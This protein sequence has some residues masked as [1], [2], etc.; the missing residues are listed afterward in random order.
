MDAGVLAGLILVAG[1]ALLLLIGAPISI[2]VGLA[3]TLAMF[4][5][6]GAENGALTSAQQMFRGINSFALL[7]IPFF[8]LAGVIMS[9]GGIAMQL[10]NAGKVLVGRVPGSSA[11]T[12]V[13]AN[14]LFGAVSGSSIAA[15][16][17]IGTTMG[18]VQAKEGYDRNFSAAVNVASAPGGM[19]V[20][21]SNLMIVYS[22]VSGTSVAALF[23]AGYLPGILWAIACSVIVYLYARKR[24]ELKETQRIGFAEGARIL[25]VATPSILLVAVVIGGILLGYFTATE[26]ACIAVFYAA[27]L[28]AIYRTIKLRDI[29][30]ILMESTRITAVVMYLV[31]VSTIMGFVL[32]FSKI[33]ELVSDTMFGFSENPV[34]LLLLIALILL[35]VGCFMDAT[36]AILIFTPIFLPIVT[37]FGVDPIHFGI[38]VIF[39]LSIGTITP[40]VGTVLFV[41]AKVADAPIEGVVRQLLPFFGVL[42]GTLI[43]VIFTPSLSLWLPEVFGL[44][45]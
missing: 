43:I 39:N 14:T 19:L 16:A 4:V 24:P 44:M 38:M 29:P 32:S 20:P 42:V 18:P 41:G 27:I 5:V 26:S 21:P 25:L 10:I 9:S 2:A 8:V 17:A 11:Q 7:A 35:V 13:A 22:L 40:P 15:A 36:P 1:I 45:P 33:P 30:G 3:S 12:T 34:V 28:S 37:S 23:M 6:V 31:G